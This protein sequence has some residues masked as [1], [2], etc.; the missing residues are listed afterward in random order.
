VRVPWRQLLI[1]RRRLVLYGRCTEA[2]SV[3]ARAR[4]RARSGG[5]SFRLRGRKAIS[6]AANRRKRFTVRLG[7]R[8]IGFVRAKLRRGR[9]VT[10]LLSFRARDR[11][12]NTISMRKRAH[13]RAVSR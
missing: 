1:S 2:C 3:S 6:L 9:Q 11:A 12:G 13:L 7:P 4:V 8:A 10:V 5:I